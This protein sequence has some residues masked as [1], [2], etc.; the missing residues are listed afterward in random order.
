M[1]DVSNIVY[2]LIKNKLDSELGVGAYKM[3]SEFVQRPAKVPFVWVQETNNFSVNN[4]NTNTENY[5]VNTYVIRVY[6]NKLSGRK[7]EALQITGYVDD[8]MRTINFTRIASLMDKNPSAGTVYT[9]DT[10]DENIF[11]WITQYEGVV[12]KDHTFYRR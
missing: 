9:N 11:G 3:S 8:V 4:D 1:I 6:S 10:H 5:I 2:T 12:G 7:A